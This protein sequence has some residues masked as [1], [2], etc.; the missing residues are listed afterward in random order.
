MSAFDKARDVRHYKIT[1]VGRPH[2][3][4]SGD[5]CGKR[6]I[7]NLGPC[8]ADTGYESRLAAV[9]KPHKTNIR[10]EFKLKAKFEFHG[11]ATRLRLPWGLVSGCGEPGVSLAASS[12]LGH[13][14]GT[15]GLIKVRNEFS[16][17]R[18]IYLSPWWNI[19]D[20]VIRRPAGFVLAHSVSALFC[21]VQLLIL[22]VK[23]RIKRF[24]RSDNNIA[25]FSA[26]ASIG[27][28]HWNKCLPAEAYAPVAAFA[29]CHLDFGL[30]NKFQYIIPVALFECSRARRL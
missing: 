25:A 2:N 4:K 21:P 11:R 30:I 5:F 15:V 14:S 23:E 29:G 1:A 12:S 28:A 22:A 18:V 27:A 16:A 10:N 26:V 24:I 7:R 17:G 20:K 19:Y 9:W 6:I 8:V 3:T 13:N